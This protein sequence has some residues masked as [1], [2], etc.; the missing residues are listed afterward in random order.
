M[1]ALIAEG[2]W[3]PLKVQLA[4]LLFLL[5]A[6]SET[7]RHL[8]SQMERSV[9]APVAAQLANAEAFFASAEA[10]AALEVSQLAMVLVCVCAS[11]V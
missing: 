10:A 5:A 11:H 8:V 7:N 1:S 3:R 6:R 9:V 2:P 4:W